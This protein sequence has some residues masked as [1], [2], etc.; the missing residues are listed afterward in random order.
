MSR[1]HGRIG[2]RSVIIAGSLAVGTVAPPVRVD[3]KGLG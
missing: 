2:L 3:E 1:P